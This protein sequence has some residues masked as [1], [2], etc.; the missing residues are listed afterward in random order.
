MIAD[1][2]LKELLLSAQVGQRMAG[3]QPHMVM[4]NP[5]ELAALVA[6]I[7]R[8]RPVFAVAYDVALQWDDQGGI[9]VSM[10]DQLTAVV[11]ASLPPPEP[12]ELLADS[13][14]ACE[15]CGVPPKKGEMV[16]V[17]ADEVIIHADCPAQAPPEAPLRGEVP[18]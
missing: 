7:T 4:V 11:E 18:Q 13:S 17:Y 15:G 8:L 1:E 6:E 3:L 16:L 14:A 12:H 5:D 10:L 2:R 9:N